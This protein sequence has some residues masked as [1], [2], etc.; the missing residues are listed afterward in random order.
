MFFKVNFSEKLFQKKTFQKC[1]Q[2]VK[3]RPDI[4]SGL[5]WV[6]TVCKC[7]QQMTPVGKEL[8]TVYL[9][10][11]YLLVSREGSVEPAHSGSLARAF[12]THIH[13]LLK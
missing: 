9:D 3:I 12:S 1:L 11:Q 7:Y 4:M 2:N 8:D 5:V 13:E 6:K 10:H